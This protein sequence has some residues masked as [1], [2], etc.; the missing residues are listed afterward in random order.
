MKSD[1]KK[2]EFEEE[3]AVF[4]EESGPNVEKL[5]VKKLETELAI[6]QNLLVIEA[7]KGNV[8]RND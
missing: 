4:K 1:G 7:K 8:L 2:E 6:S 5:K 3:F